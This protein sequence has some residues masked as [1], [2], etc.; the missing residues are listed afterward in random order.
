[1]AMEV[2]PPP[3]EQLKGKYLTLGELLPKGIL[4]PEAQGVVDSEAEAP[5]N[6]TEDRSLR[7]K[8]TDICGLTCTFC[9]NEGTPVND[10]QRDSGRV[11][12]F[13]IDNG[14]SFHPGVVMPDG[15]FLD[16]L[17]SLKEKLGINEI[18]M[19]GGEP[20]MHPKF[21]NL[22]KLCNSLGFKVNITSNGETG[23]IYGRV[24]D[25]G[26]SNVNFS[27]FGTTP[28][29]LAAV[30]AAKYQDI[31]IAQ[32]KIDQLTRAIKSCTDNGITAKANIVMQGSEHAGRIGRIV[33]AFG[34]KVKIRILPDLSIGTPSIASIYEYLASRGAIAIQ[35]NFA[36][37]SS[38]LSVD[39]RTDDGSEIGFKQIRPTR[40]HECENC[41]RNNPVDCP[42]GFY[43][44][45]LYPDAK[46]GYRVGVCLLRMDLTEK[47]D[48]FLAGNLPAQIVDIRNKE[49]AELQ[50]IS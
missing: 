3:L 28:A 31:R 39:Y 21:F 14:V 8:A 49:Y 37:G 47:L 9:H 50:S 19:T 40:I 4:S 30:Q 18:H 26:I 5:M 24:P 46:G 20:T 11:S 38:N 41:S 48:T 2:K 32:R 45:R 27:I 16:A 36:A 6:V 22:T 17:L 7:V 44:T 34:D 33:E 10:A 43:G 29:E 35:R 42:E 1:M 23:A 13:Q 12:V 15:D 25:T